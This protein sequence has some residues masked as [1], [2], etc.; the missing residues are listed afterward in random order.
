MEAYFAD[1]RRSERIVLDLTVVIF[2]KNEE[3]NILECITSVKDFSEVLVIDSNSTDSTREI[4]ESLGVSVIEFEWNR[5][6]PKKRQWTLDQFSG[7][8]NWILFLD[9]DERMSIAL[10]KELEIFL[11][12]DS[13]AFAG[14][15]I[16]I[17]YYFAGKRLRFGQRPKKLVL[18]RVGSVSYPIIDD[19]NSE[20]MGELEGHYQPEVKGKTRKFKSRI[21]HNDKDPISTWMTRHVNYAKWEAHLIQNLM[22]KNRVDSSKGMVASV[23]HKLP[24]RPLLFFMY[25]YVLK[26]GFLDGKA[27]FDYAVAKAWYYWLSAVI[28]RERS[29]SES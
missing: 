25:S 9:A 8:N 12:G 13:D 16:E 22:E 28:A 4:A 6:Y 10:Q 15:L 11:A 24:A 3:S 26:F 18:L 27:G 19:L 7:K 14:G 21:V 5:Q 2:T 20:G 23:A 17:D 29:Q 1:N